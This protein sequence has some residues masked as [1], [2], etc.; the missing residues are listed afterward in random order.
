MKRQKMLW[1]SHMVPYPPVAGHLIRSFNLIKYLSD[2]FEI[3]LIAQN[4]KNA[5]APYFESLEDGVAKS[6]AA[7]SEFC[8][9]VHIHDE[10]I[11]SDAFDKATATLLSV[12]MRDTYTVR[13]LQQ[14]SFRTVVAETLEKNT[15]DVVHIDSIGLMSSLPEIG[16][17]KGFKVLC[18]HNME[19]H[20]MYRRASK[21]DN[22]LLRSVFKSEAKKLE[23]L[24]RKS[25]PLFDLNVTCS[26]EDTKRFEQLNSQSKLIEIP[27]GFDPN[28]LKDFKRKPN[29]LKVLFIGTM[30]WYPNVDAVEVLLKDVWGLILSRFPEA[31]LD[32]IGANP[33][34]AIVELAEKSERVRLHGFVDEI[35][36]FYEQATAFMCPISDGGGTKLKIIE[37]MALK[38]PLIANEIACEGL[39]VPESGAVF[40][41]NAPE[42][43]VK[44][45]ERVVES[46]DNTQSFVEKSYNHV[47]ENFAF[48]GIAS[49]YASLVTS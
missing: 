35:Q 11:T 7:L 38:L 39:N 41:A 33:P 40:F 8:D 46:P 6:H 43:Y 49:K 29:G 19:S 34:S 20:M 17:I 36:P 37:V 25:M 30:D 31:E 42:D 16:A 4:Q 47:L 15:F 27:N 3:T 45:L 1:V 23:A 22:F 28:K 32:I 26:E 44:Q 21:T 14:K 10:V 48:D 9:S 12:L 13:W 24:E 5:M 18:H 2:Y